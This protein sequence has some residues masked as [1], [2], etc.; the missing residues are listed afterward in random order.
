[1]EI[2]GKRSGLS[3]NRREN[4]RKNMRLMKK[5]AAKKILKAWQTGF[6]K[7]ESWKNDEIC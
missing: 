4:C 6:I 5:T 1:M 7:L 2:S 3:R